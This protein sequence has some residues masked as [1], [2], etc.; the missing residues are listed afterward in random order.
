MTGTAVCPACDA[1]ASR[2]F[3]SWPSVPVHSC[4]LVDDAAS[5]RRF[6]RGDLRLCVC[7]ACGFVFNADFDSRHSDYSPRYEETQGFS[8]HFRDFV[9]ALAKEW[10][11][12]YGLRGKRVVEIGCGKGEF[13]VALAA[14]GIGHG[15]GIDPG[16]HPERIEPGRG[17]E[18]LTWV[19]GFF[20]ADLPDLDADA[21]VCRHTLEHV[22][23]V[24]GFMRLVRAALGDR[25]DTVVLFELPDVLRVLREGAFWD[26]YYE[27]CSYFS[28]GSLARLFRRSGFEVLDVRRAYDDQYLLVE[29][30][31]AASA[32]S[33]GAPLPVEDDLGD[34]L[35]A[36]DGF[37]AAV[38]TVTRTWRTELADRARAGE[39]VVIWGSGSKGVA[40]L[41]ALGPHADDV[42]FAV[43]INPYKQGRYMAGSGHRIDG[44]GRLTD[45]PPSLVVA[46]NPVYVDEIR[47]ELD[48]LG[49]RADLRAV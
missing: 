1:P 49:V 41:A 6:P 16:V 48:S 43:D 18:R 12:R 42:A 45:S 13:L 44:P 20:P 30:R 5:A 10:V 7:G 4:L 22:P 47:A 11:D 39:S 3:M 23:D 9:E 36:V 21:V 17:S 14:Q 34:V 40:F 26:V 15:T 8:P 28:A 27:H 32:G 31:P 37:A 29:A 38:D 33:T 46:M 35:S 24:A 2:E 19:Q 25:V